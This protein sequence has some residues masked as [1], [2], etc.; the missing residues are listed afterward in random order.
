MKTHYRTILYL[1]DIDLSIQLT[2]C[3]KIN[4]PR[5]S[6]RDEVTCANCRKTKAFRGAETKGKTK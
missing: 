3:G 6:N 2:A 1:E 4:G 5:K